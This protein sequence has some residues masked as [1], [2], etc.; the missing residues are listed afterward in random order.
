MIIY[1]AMCKEEAD[2]TTRVPDWSMKRFKW[3]SPNLDW[4]KSR[5][6]D[7]K[8]NNSRHKPKY[9]YL[10]EFEWDGLKSD[11]VSTNEIQFDRRRNPNIKL[12]KKI[13]VGVY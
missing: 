10:C 2:R 9:D 7:G 11:F 4:I 8:F 3:F 6:L 5:V 12:V 1:R 13:K